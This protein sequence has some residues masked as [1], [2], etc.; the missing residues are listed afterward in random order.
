MPLGGFRRA[1]RPAR[2]GEIDHARASSSADRTAPVFQRPL[3]PRSVATAARS[4][5]AVARDFV[6]A[7]MRIGLTPRGDSSPDSDALGRCGLLQNQANAARFQKRSERF[8][9]RILRTRDRPCAKRA[10][11]QRSPEAFLQ[12]RYLVRALKHS[13]VPH[14]NQPFSG[15]TRLLENPKEQ[16]FRLFASVAMQIH[17]RL[18]REVSGAQFPQGL[19]V[20]AWNCSFDVLVGI[21][22]LDRSIALYERVELGQCFRVPVGYPRQVN[23]GRRRRYTPFASHRHDLADGLSKY[24]RLVGLFRRHLRLRAC[25]LCRRY[26][27]LQGGEWVMKRLDTLGPESLRAPGMNLSKISLIRLPDLPPHFHFPSL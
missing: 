12:H 19:T 16:I 23:L 22:E 10:R 2:A 17:V 8:S 27:R 24:H 5:C 6:I 26:N 3:A 14:Q 11:R 7:P 13:A 4:P 18:H 20:E 15:A 21:A 9:G 25:R 1:T